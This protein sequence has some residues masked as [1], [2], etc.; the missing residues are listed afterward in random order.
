MVK[1]Y[2]YRVLM[3]KSEGKRPL[4][5]D[6]KGRINT[7]CLKEMGWNGVDWINL[8]HNKRKWQAVIN[9]ETNLGV[10]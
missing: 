1:I 5:R 3:W 8:A 7:M 10:P 2:A 6:I 9:M 4:G